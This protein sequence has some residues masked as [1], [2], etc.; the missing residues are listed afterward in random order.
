MTYIPGI[1]QAYTTA[2][3]ARATEDKGQTLGQDE[4][5]TLLVAQ[6]Q[7]QDPLNPT[8]STEWTS[9]L[10]QYSQLEQSMNLNTTMDKL[11]EG[12]KSS[13]RLSAL[14]L[15]GKQ[16]VVE[17]STFQLG[18]GSVEIGYRVDGTAGDIKLHIE[19]SNGR[20]VST[21][22]P[23]D[24]TE[25]NHFLTWQGMDQNGQHLPVGEY[26]IVVE[27]QSTE[28]NTV[29]VSPLV[30]T[31]VTG[32][33]LGESGAVLLTDVGEFSLSDIYGVYDKNQGQT[34]P[35]EGSSPPPPVNGTNVVEEISAAMDGAGII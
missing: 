7:N 22:Y 14:S 11:V 10:A 3:Q 12:Q 18:D 5:L 4:F 27:A 13:E 29:G 1:S 28:G 34:E 9:Q 2:D 8:D 20:R 21:L 31:D 35:A 30:R 6:M 24:R 26:S 15:I 25:G 16:A 33:D 32:I 19:D 23:A 17:G